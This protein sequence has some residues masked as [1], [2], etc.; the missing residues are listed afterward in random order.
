MPRRPDNVG[1]PINNETRMTRW[2]VSANFSAQKCYVRCDRG[3][4]RL[5]RRTMLLSF[6]FVVRVWTTLFFQMPQNCQVAPLCGGGSNE[7]NRRKP[8]NAQYT[9][10][11]GTKHRWINRPCF[12]FNKLNN[13]FRSTCCCYFSIV[14][15]WEMGIGLF[16]G[17]LIHCLHS[18]HT[19]SPRSRSRTR[20]LPFICAENIIIMLFW[21][22]RN[23]ERPMSANWICWFCWLS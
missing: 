20:I 3:C 13:I 2:S 5:A 11:P 23:G 7:S 18:P 22:A 19:H 15:C 1:W 10:L 14:F 17:R 21:T 8:V 4:T 6:M 16:F 9:P 12:R